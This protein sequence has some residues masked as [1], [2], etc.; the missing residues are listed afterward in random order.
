M[1][2]FQTRFS[3]STATHLLSS[4]QNF[5]VLFKN[6]D[7]CLKI[8][9]YYQLVGLSEGAKGNVQGNIKKIDFQQVNTYKYVTTNYMR[10]YKEK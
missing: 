7:L 4:C 5:V 1:P 10:N 8:F 3:R 6:L 9:R 2:R